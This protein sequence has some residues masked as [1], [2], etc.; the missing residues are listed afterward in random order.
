[1]ADIFALNDTE[2]LLQFTDRSRHMTRVGKCPRAAFLST[3]F[4]PTGYGIQRKAKSVPLASGTMLHDA[5]EFILRAV[6]A[7]DALPGDHIVREG[8]ALAELVQRGDGRAR[9]LR[10]DRV[11]SGERHQAGVGLAAA[12][13]DV[14]PDEGGAADG[15]G[16]DRSLGVV[17]SS[18][19]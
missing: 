10:A 2:I 6:M 4:G 13:R 5:H 16:T 9:L 17:F 8:I 14:G 1:M 7:T 15:A 11:A 3:A 19:G 12:G 18:G